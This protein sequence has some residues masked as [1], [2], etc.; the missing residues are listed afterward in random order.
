MS[1]IVNEQALSL[2]IKLELQVI[3][4]IM[5]ENYM[6]N[7]TFLTWQVTTLHAKLLRSVDL[8]IYIIIQCCFHIV[9]QWQRKLC[10]FFTLLYKN[11]VKNMN[12]QYVKVLEK[13]YMR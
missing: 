7:V 1:Y 9:L 2:L 11:V 6:Y 12:K 4:D 3:E 13:Y 8:Y 10:S 5:S